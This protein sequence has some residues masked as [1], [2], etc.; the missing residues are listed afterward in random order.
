VKNRNKKGSQGF[1]PEI[2]VNHSLNQPQTFGGIPVNSPRLVNSSTPYK[3]NKTFCSVGR[4]EKISVPLGA[5]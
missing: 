1:H 5:H 2:E 3:L 4:R